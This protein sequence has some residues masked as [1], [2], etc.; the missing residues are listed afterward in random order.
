MRVTHF[1]QSKDFA[2]RFA[3]CFS[4]FVGTALLAHAQTYSLVRLVADTS[5]AQAAKTDPNLVNPWGLAA[6]A[7]N[8]WWVSDNGTGL[9]T[10]YDGLGNIESLVVTIPPS[11]SA[12]PGSTGTPTGI[13]ANS[14]SDFG[15]AA[16]VFDS[17]DGTISSWSGA[18]SATIKIDKG[19]AAVYK[20]LTVAQLNGNSVLYAANF[21]AGTVD[22]FD[23]NFKQVALSATA[24][25]DPK[26]PA[27]FAP[28]N[29]QTLNGNVFVAFAKQDSAKHDE[30]DGPGL[31]LVDEF[32]SQ[33]RLIMRF[34]NGPFM[35]A[36]WGLA[37]AP[38]NF[39][40]FSNDVLVGNFGSGTIIAFDPSSGKVKGL[41]KGANGK[42]VA[43]PG[44]W[45]IA[46]GLGG[47][48]GPSNWLYFTAG[49]KAEAH[50]LFGYIVAE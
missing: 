40:T 35:N 48:T 6:I 50:G 1:K 9:S 14:S 12:L 11:A 36:P 23:T 26:L 3:L 43:V 34:Q 31:G 15:G 18:P 24:F 30:I 7:G 2:A 5:A 13:I 16:F 41:L 22:A 20:G 29:V 21:R 28:F 45:A 27:G 25:K 33:G 19:A 4:M 46:F 49:I 44:L 8:P 39:G 37:V 42:A 17:E 38:S 10:L 47:T 32:D